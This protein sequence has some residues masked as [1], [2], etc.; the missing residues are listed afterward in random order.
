VAVIDDG[1]EVDHEDL[2]G[3]IIATYNADDESS[4]VGYYGSEGAHG[5]SCAGFIAAPLN[6]M[7]IVGVAPDA[8]LILIKHENGSDAS[9]I[10]A[11]EYAKNQGAKVISCSW[12]T[13]Q[14][15]EAVEAKLQSLY[16]AGI[17]VLFA[18]GNDGKDLDTE[19][20]D[21]ES[22]VE[23][24]IGV[25]A[26]SESNDVTSYSNYGANI[27]LLAPGG[28]I[29]ISSGLLAL[30]D[31]G[32]EGLKHQRGLV[33]ENYSFTE[34]T[35]FACPIAAGVVAL[36]YSREPTITPKEVRERLIETAQK[37]GSATYSEEG[38]D[39][40]KRRGYGKIDA[41]KAVGSL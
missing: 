19:G 4:D 10:R 27:D 24:V 14:V 41:A 9:L 5:S 15:S 21:D 38:F 39:I 22:E 3:N 12:G 36:L 16:N 6:G 29:E 33:N 20:L 35:S 2:Q 32:R 31:M 18:S 26:S 11:F 34:G 1:F 37:V 25:G 40:S 17:T 8:K 23:W 30:D 13:E 28:D 7:G